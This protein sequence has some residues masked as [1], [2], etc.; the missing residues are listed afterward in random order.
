MPGLKFE[1]AFL[2]YVGEHVQGVSLVS[3]HAKT[4]HRQKSA[5]MV[6]SFTAGQE[7]HLSWTAHCYCCVTSLFPLNLKN[8]RTQSSNSP[9]I[10]WRAAE[11]ALASANHWNDPSQLQ[12]PHEP[13]ELLSAETVLEFQRWPRRFVAAVGSKNMTTRHCV[14]IVV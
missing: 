13:A 3:A 1:S 4:A 5:D 6:F 7:M 9:P 8:I 11:C 2:E 14:V 10:L 12:N